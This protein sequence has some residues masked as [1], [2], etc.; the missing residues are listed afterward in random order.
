MVSALLL[1]GGLFLAAPAGSV[2]IRSDEGPGRDLEMEQFLSTA[3]ILDNQPFGKGVTGIR[4]L[5][6]GQDGKILHAAFKDVD[7]LVGANAPR[8]TLARINEADRYQYD[9]AAYRLDRL[10]GRETVPVAVYREIDGRPGAV[11]VWIE[12]TFDE[13]ERLK[14]A[15]S[16]CERSALLRDTRYRHLFDILI[17][18][19]D[20]NQGNILYGDQD[21]RMY[22]IDHS[23]AFRIS[24]RRPD[25]LKDVSVTLPG[26]FSE[27]LAALDLQ[28]LRRELEPWLNKIQIKALL[29]RR[30]KLL[31]ARR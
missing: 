30:D 8:N 13:E 18:N 9:I 15:E 1:A 21:C 19:E 17:Y 4:R 3:R 10:L 22:L 20:R 24:T 25:S 11:S 29:K 28:T 26:D 2:A 12:N 5:T 16:P 23:R 31:D 7:G 6:L 14:R 27:R